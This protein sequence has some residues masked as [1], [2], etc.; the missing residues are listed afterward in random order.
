MRVATPL[1]VLGSLTLAVAQHTLEINPAKTKDSKFAIATFVENNINFAT[2]GGL[3]AELIRNRAF[4]EEGVAPY[5]QAI[6]GAKLDETK[7]NQ[8]SSAL[9]NSLIITPQGNQD[10]GVKNVG[11]FGIPVS[12]QTYKVS[13]YARTAKAT[14]VTVKAGLYGAQ[15]NKEFAKVNIPLDLTTEWKQFTADLV[16]TQ[17]ASNANNTFGLIFPRGT[18]AVQ[19]N[20]ISLFPPT[21]EGTVGRKDLST[22]LK[23]LNAP[24]SRLPGGN[25]LEGNEI[26]QF[27]NWSERVGPLTSRP[28]LPSVWAGVDTGGYGL[29]EALDL[30]EKLGSEPILDLYAGYSLNKQS[31]AQKDLTPYVNLAVHQL[32]YIKDPQGSSA[33]AKRREAN[34][35]AQ[36]WTLNVVEIG[37][38]DWIS[39]EAIDTYGYR[40]KAFYKALKAEFPDVTFLASSPYSTDKSKL[41]GIDQHNYDVP[42]FAY[43]QFHGYDS[44]PRNGTQIMEL[45]YAV[46][47][48]GRCGDAQSTDIYNNACRLTHP[49]LESALAEGAWTMGFERN[50]DLITAAAYA[51]LFRNA[52]GSQWSPDLIEFNHQTVAPSTSYWVQYAFGNNRIDKIFSANLTSG[53]AGP[54]YWSAGSLKGKAKTLSLKLVNSD[55]KQQT[56]TVDLAG[57][58]SFGTSAGSVWRISGDNLDATNTVSHPDTIVPK[59]SSVKANGRKL[60]L[61]LPGNSFQVVNI[62]L[63]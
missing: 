46:L 19:I 49:T 28:S 18:P 45:E 60:N 47:N 21:Y 15:T 42:S 40:Y 23:N 9:P 16:S 51:P 31:V 52:D 58:T 63:A 35:R 37:N 36:P 14:K 22:T 62:D 30:I 13:F 55:S 59:T 48:N 3:Y 17:S 27:W 4:Q 10:F 6:G 56:L 26:S 24:Y 12:A 53:H 32:H 5:W 54:I 33:F 25:Q 41:E 29:H 34:G 44:W 43:A 7:N 20:L 8:L 39:Q 2:D 38:E 50:G 57:S 11:Y 1:L 61:T